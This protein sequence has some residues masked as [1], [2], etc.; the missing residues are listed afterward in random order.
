MVTKEKLPFYIHKEI[1]ILGKLL[2]KLC[3]FPQLKTL[4]VAV[5]IK[6][7]HLELKF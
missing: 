4:K 6:I 2:R 3:T 1:D 7:V 5:A